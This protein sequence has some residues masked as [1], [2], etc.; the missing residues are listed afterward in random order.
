VALFCDLRDQLS[1]DM[2]TYK[3]IF[4]ELWVAVII[5][6]LTFIITLN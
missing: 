6:L 4:K 3:R 2:S 1:E 5:L